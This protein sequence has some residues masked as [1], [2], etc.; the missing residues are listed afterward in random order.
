M[1]KILGLDIGTTSI[2]WAIIEASD[3]KNINDVT[4][5]GAETDIN[6]VRVGIHKDAI[7]VRIIAQDTERFD[8][9]QTLNDPKG[10]TLTP[11]ANRRKY[12]SSRRMK[13]RYKLRRDK[14]GRVLDFI[15]MNP[16]KAYYTNGKG[17][18]GEYNDIG[19]AIYQ[20]R[21]K[22]LREPISLNELGR[23][24]SHLNQWRGYSSDRFA[25]EEKPKFDYY[26]AEV[27]ELDNTN[28]VAITDEHNKEEIKYYKVPIKI[29]FDEP[30]N[31][32]DEENKNIVTELDGILFKKDIDFR[33]G[34]FVTIKKPEF[35]QD[36]KGKT[37][38]AEYYK[39]SFTVP[40]PTDWNYK[41]QTL[42]KT[43]TE[44]CEAGNT[45]GSYFYQNFYKT[46]SI[47]RIRNQVVNRKWYEDEL[48]KILD[49][50]YLHHKD[51]FHQL[52]IEETIKV[53]F[54]DYRPILNDV[55]QKEG[56]KE[57]L[58][59]L[60]KEKI[61]FFQ[62]PWQQ[63]K[64]KGQC[65]FEK[66]KVKKKATV[67]GTGKK[68]I[69]EEHVGRTVIPRSHPLF[70]E[71]KIWQQ[72]NNVR[73][74][75]K[76]ADEK[77][78][79]FAN[80]KDFEKYTGKKISEIKQMLYDTLQKTKTLSWKNF[81]ETELGLKSI[82]EI[83]DKATGEVI[84]CHFEY[85]FRKL[86]RD[87]VT[88]EDIKLKGNNTK[89]SL[90]NILTGKKDEWFNQIHS[91][92]QKITNLQLLWELIY[93][94]TNGDSNKV[95]A[96]IETHFDFDK[97]ICLQLA[98]LKFDDAGMGNLSAK[99]IRQI[100][101]LMSDGKDITDRTLEKVNS[102]LNLNTSIEEKAKN[103]DEKLESLKDFVPDK[104]ARLRLSKFN[105]ANDFTYLNYWEATAVRYGSHSTQKR[106]AFGTM[107]PVERH[108]M[109]NPIV[110]KIVN[111]TI[112]I[113]NEIQKRYGF[114]EVRIELS[115]EL[116]AS[117]DE[118]QQMWEAMNSNASKNEWA[119]QML[120]ELKAEF[121][122]LDTDVANKSNL[123]KIK[124]IEDVVKFKN[125]EEY[126]LKSKEYK[127]S[128][129]SKAEVRKYLMWL[130]QNFKCP[131]TNQPI[132]FTDVFARGKV[133][134]IEHIIPRER[135][136]VNSY[137]NK[138]ITWRE[139]NQTKAGHG[140]RTAYEFIVSKR[141]EE[142]VKVGDNEF[143]LISKEGWESHVKSMFP[144]GAKQTN[145]LRKE[146]PEDPI[147]RTLN[148]TQYINKKLKEKLSELVG[149]QKVWVTSGAVTDILR[150]R[151]H[152]N[153]I[154]KELM[155]E[156]F[157]NFEIPTGK[158]SFKL[159]TLTEQQTMFATIQSV[160]DNLGV[161]EVYKIP[162]GKKFIEIKDID[163]L[164]KIHSE[165]NV[166]IK[167][168]SISIN[169]K[170]EPYDY[171]T[172]DKAF[173][174][175]SLTHYTKQL[176]NK[177]GNYEDREVF[178]GYSKRL[179][180]RHHALDA[181]IIACT[182]QNHIQYINT[183]NAI[184][185]A[186][187]ENDESKKMKY[188]MLKEDVCIGNSSKRFKTPWAENNFI[189]DVKKALSE[190]VISHKNTRLLISPSKHRVNKDI[191][192]NKI[193]SIRGELHK[194]TNYAKKNYFEGGKTFINKL[195]P[196]ILKAKKEN[197]Y[198]T[199]VHSKT[200]EE[201]IKETVLKEKYQKVL[202][203]LFSKYENEQLNDGVC[204][205]Y[206]K[207]ILKE[208]DT[209]K[210]LINSQTKDPLLWLSTYSDK[211]KSSRPNGLSMNLN[212]AK[213]VNS[214]ADPRIKRL[215]GYRLKYV[216]DQ[217]AA[218][219]L[220]DIDKK[221]KDKLKRNVETLPLYSNAIYEVRIKENENY[222]WVELKDFNSS[223]FDK[224]DYSNLN[225]KKYNKKNNTEKVKNLL[226]EADIETLKQTYFEEPIFLSTPVEVKKVRQMSY[227]QNLYE[228]TPKRYV[229]VEETFMT[230][231]FQER[232][233]NG[234][235]ET[236]KLRIPK[237]LKFIDAVNIITTEKPN[238]IDYKKLIEKERSNGELQNGVE[239]DLLFT[240]SKNDVVYLPGD[241]LSK[242]ELEEIDWNNKQAI[243]PRLYIVKD[244]NPSLSKIVFQQL[245]KADSIK[246]SETDAKSLFNNPELKEQTEEIKYGTVPMLQRC[247]KVFT[248][249]LGKKVT[250]YWVFPNGCWNK[251]IAKQLGLV[252]FNDIPNPGAFSVADEPGRSFI[253]LPKAIE[254]DN[255]LIE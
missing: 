186:D 214:I 72:I 188:N 25:K 82:K 101:P 117:M 239:Y 9:G 5:K 51:F 133:V 176:N 123:D 245:Y 204:K 141:V 2:G 26:V 78:D 67:K 37:V 203:P 172:S 197:Q 191:K 16:D 243:A 254:S 75:Q 182:K 62:R 199:M 166:L 14:L 232:S 69:V 3:E 159:K 147:N 120:R 200:L 168:N 247:I 88:Y 225:D 137:A 112:A 184:N 189:P 163:E 212:D 53:A 126:K 41:Y 215:A 27:L 162:S 202:I 192:P 115:R 76:T 50:Q 34:D 95:A 84:K 30:Y 64:N 167:E 252:D 4:G 28:K 32:G 127:L 11:T 59:C 24:L 83:V 105:A 231:F 170:I 144:R 169:Q 241:I 151:W 12:R 208:I 125:S 140:N 157:E 213:E 121:A 131:Y 183:L 185:T 61:I 10:S 96:I 18:R 33:K 71:F 20:L 116:K 81:A 161:F 236:S 38:L 56:I 211:N 156:R 205:E 143:P 118:R 108:S 55:L 7:G 40:D 70:Q 139:V 158:K 233:K 135:Y 227:F 164:R 237:F 173:E 92:K 103:K 246:I 15:G 47:P 226:S 154:M 124:I 36:K 73:I 86:K 107:K 138:V 85:N 222:K 207:T 201:I 65:P 181:I 44:W 223:D 244:M 98:N 149:E 93:D 216:N 251:E 90:Q 13:S 253:N 74:Y 130:E 68:E 6:N 179:D 229:Q 104:K 255:P 29:R 109:N 113:V 100:L 250:P 177:T 129:P 19:K 155:R 218:I 150:D 209:N 160:L 224:I 235:T 134:E 102:L 111:E 114:D 249:K 174:T 42:Q 220:M 196:Q 219:D 153:D 198:Q 210:L 94:I 148:E 80:E 45:V 106:A 23:I 60:I 79:L 110:E 8:K 99:A 46:Q 240:L 193:A 48:D 248:D 187:Q 230:Y 228:V 206:S 178:E 97:S 217:K 119:K 49:F 21:D 145:L 1:K 128:E 91:D 165:L 22:A 17:K 77:I 175:K 146:I 194:E 152:L 39:I 180:H 43:L 122:E 87:K 89:A 54:K 58:K 242:E 221:E 142:K 57:Q 190:I 35:K 132:P 234:S 66:I 238:S 63:A 31:L 136:Y 171:S 195:I 52:N